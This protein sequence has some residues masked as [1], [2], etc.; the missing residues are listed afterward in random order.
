MGEAKG[1]RKEVGQGQEAG[2]GVVREKVGQ[3]QME[4]EADWRKG[5]AGTGGRGGW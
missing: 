4:G 1:K 2:R 3:G 5:G